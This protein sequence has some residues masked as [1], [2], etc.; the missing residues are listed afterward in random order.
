MRERER[1]RERERNVLEDCNKI[2]LK[3]IYCKWDM[4]KKY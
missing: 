4:Y 1:E 3:N 2:C